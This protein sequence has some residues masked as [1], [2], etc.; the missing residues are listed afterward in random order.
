[1]SALLRF[2][3]AGMAVGGVL[4]FTR[5]APIFA[6]VPPDM[7]FPPETTED[8]VRLVEISGL[9]WPLSHALGLIAVML[10][11]F[12]YW[13]HAARL[14][15]AGHVFVGAAAATIAMVS[16]AA[17]A[18]ALVIDGFFVPKMAYAHA[19]GGG[20][21]PDVSDIAAVHAR[22]L[23]FFTPGVFLMFIA[24]GVLSSRMLHGFIHS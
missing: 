22:A 12:G 10:F 7:A 1:M 6:I 4:F 21:A 20:V 16:F 13:A 24:V 15:K 19:A 2:A 18:A 5:M 3:G 23:A 11:S 9:R 17:L 14:A 8:L